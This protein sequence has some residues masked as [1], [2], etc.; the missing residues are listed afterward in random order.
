MNL[1]T[2]ETIIEKAI[3]DRMKRVVPS[4][5]FFETTM[6]LVTKEQSERSLS[7]KAVP[8]PYQFSLSRISGRATQIAMTIAMT[9]LIAVLVIKT[10]G[11][12]ILQ[13]VPHTGPE[14]YLPSEVS[15]PVSTDLSPDQVVAMLM[16]DAE[17]E[18]A[19]GASE[20]EDGLALAADQDVV[21]YTII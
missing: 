14:P 12:N 9:A 19:L 21:D 2:N 5:A 17:T 1:D 6:A 18:G 20:E 10:G 15:T 8:S 7:M 11:Q 13:S 3:R 16:D 4:R